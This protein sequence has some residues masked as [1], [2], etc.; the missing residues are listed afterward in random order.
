M[1]YLFYILFVAFALSMVALEWLLKDKNKY[2]K[3]IPFIALLFAYFMMAILKSKNVG[4][5]SYNYGEMYE[6]YKLTSFV[7]ILKTKNVEVG[8]YG[9]THIFSGVLNLPIIIFDSFCFLI[10]CVCLFFSFYKQEN[11][12]VFLAVFLFVGFYCMSFS[13][14]RQSIAISLAT[15]AFTILFEKS[16][17]NAVLKYAEYFVLIA[18]ASL[19]HKA[20]LMLFAVPVLTMLFV[21]DYMIPYFPILVLLFSPLLFG[22][23]IILASANFDRN[24]NVFDGRVALTLIGETVFVVLFYL[25]Y[26]TPL[27]KKVRS[28]M[29][30]SDFEYSKKDSD[31]L[32]LIYLSCLFVAFNTA[33]T[34]ITR[35]SMFFYLG[36]TYYLLKIAS[37]INKPKLKFAYLL[38]ITLLLGAYFVYSTPTLGLVPYEFR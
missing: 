28:K 23:L 35:F 9:L 5:D 38:A 24:I 32:I 29:D 20:S 14:L 4:I 36:I 13:G 11:K 27:G 2:I 3:A 19:F 21:K 25:L 6:R 33:S 15:L 22:R 10:I 16:G 1:G 8:F 30:V 26:M 31:Y 7:E 18:L 12:T 37:T 34:V 17:K